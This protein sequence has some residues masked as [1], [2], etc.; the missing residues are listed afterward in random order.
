MQLREAADVLGVHYQTAYH[1]VRQGTLPARKVGRGYEI[2]D[3]GLAEF[4]AQRQAGREPTQ[5][6]EVRDW[7]AQ[8]DQLYAAIAQG[9]ETQA[10]HWLARLAAGVTITDLCERV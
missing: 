5:Q 2:D 4:A 1:W 10:R 9:E 7:Q 8:A 6:I 3:A